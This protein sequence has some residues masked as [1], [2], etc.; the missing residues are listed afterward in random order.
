M[1]EEIML[2]ALKPV[3]MEQWWKF[4]LGIDYQVEKVGKTIATLKSKDGQI[5]K[6][7]LGIG[8]YPA[9]PEFW[10]RIK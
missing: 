10:Q 7:H 5:K 8:G 2:L 3:A 6:M 9:F 1:A 4:H